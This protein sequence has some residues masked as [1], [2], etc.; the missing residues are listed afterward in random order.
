MNA[1]APYPAPPRG[2]IAELVTPLT[3]DGRL[4]R[5]GLARLVAGVAGAADGI[6]AGSPGAGEGLELPRE[7]RQE[8]F[9]AALAAVAGRTPLFLGIAADSS[10]ETR[11]LA[12]AVQE[13]CRTSNYAAPVFLVDLPLWHHSNRGLPQACQ[14]LLDDV[15]LPLLL[16]NL[17]DLMRRRAPVFKR[18]NLRTHV[19]KKLLALPGLVGL[20]YQ[21]EMRRFLNYHHA[22]AARAGF[23]FYEAD[24]L[25]FLTRPGAWGVVSPGAQLAPASWQRVT[26]SC[27]SPEETGAEAGPRFELWDLS[28]RL[29][30][31]ARLYAPHPAALLK[32]VLAARGLIAGPHL[33]PGTPAASAALR[34]A[35]L[36]AAGVTEEP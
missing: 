3:A 16:L 5:G 33:A 19:F 26:R 36:A 10:G 1:P 24:E 2:L 21:G 23:A 27:L 13:L 12:L 14:T 22:A 9:A 28:R 30:E 34:E 8:L 4:D 29:L 32:A 15:S 25:S 20:I 17:P 6:L 35:M 31:L 11:E 18:R 7:L